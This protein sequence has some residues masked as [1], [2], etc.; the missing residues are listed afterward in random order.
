MFISD[1]Y[2]ILAYQN[3]PPGITSDICKLQLQN[4]QNSQVSRRITF[5]QA[6]TTIFIHYY[7]SVITKSWN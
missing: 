2:Y 5:M 4:S 7:R 6:N 1:T 3:P